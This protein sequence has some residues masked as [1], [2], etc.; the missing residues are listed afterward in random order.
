MDS[1]FGK[2]LKQ[3]K[4][5]LNTL[6][7]FQ[8]KLT[9]VPVRSSSFAFGPQTPWSAWPRRWERLP[10][11][12]WPWASTKATVGCRSSGRPGRGEMEEG[13]RWIE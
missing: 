8:K 4:K 13:M 1:P 3:N 2:I 6:T 7:D 9:H 5:T 11:T 12:S 10:S